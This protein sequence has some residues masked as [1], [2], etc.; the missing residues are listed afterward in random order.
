MPGFVKDHASGPFGWVSDKVAHAAAHDADVFI[1]SYPEL[2]G[3]GLPNL[4]GKA[5]LTSTVSEDRLATFRELGADLVVDV[6]PQP[7]E[8]AVVPALYEAMVAA[9]LA[10]GEELATHD[11]AAFIQDAG[12]ESR[13]LWPRGRRRKSRFSFVIHPLSTEYFKNV[14]PLGQLTSI[15]GMTG[16][17]GKGHR[18]RPAVRLLPR[19]RHR[20]RHRR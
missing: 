9:T 15:P 14:E 3:F 2:M 4:A 7:F 8:F 13:L 5:V 20:L 12:F 16:V 19:H 18:L 10:P 6:T 1:G 17:V 11:L